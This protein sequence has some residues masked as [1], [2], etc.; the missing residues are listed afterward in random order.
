MSETLIHV[1]IEG[2]PYDVV[3]GSDILPTLGGRIA[4]ICKPKRAFVVTETNVGPLYL[5]QVSSSLEE[6]G[7]AVSTHTYI[8][9]ERSKTI[10]TWARICRAMANAGCDR[11]TV[12]V[13]LGGGVTGDMAGFAAAAFM[14]GI[15]FVQ[16]PTSLLAMVDSSVGGKTGVDIPE[17]KNLVGAFLQPELV[18]ADVNCLA[19]LPSPQLA[20][21]CGE[22]IKH[23]VLADEG[24]LDCLERKPL[25]ASGRTHQEL[26]EIVAAN[27]R[28]K[29]DVVVADE[30]EHGLRQMLNL[31]HTL[32][33]AIE[34]ASD[35]SLGHGS[36][37]AT[38][39]CMVARASASLG[40]C[41]L[42]VADRIERSVAA[43]G[44]P[45]HTDVP[46]GRIL[47][48]AAHD[49]KRHDEGVNLIIPCKIGSCEIRRVNFEELRTVIELG[50]RREIA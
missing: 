39:L 48:L 1:G 2:A 31:G 13:A 50:N 5:E 8:A 34:A 26:V 38:G 46:V 19:T 28:I 7:I 23:A 25:T 3:V 35:Y 10:D 33:H 40:W 9:G 44:L 43:H 17:G 15:R 16:V 24:L 45:T 22:V 11:D 21:A 6:V 20:D 37:V 47:E 41:T 14:R 36:C 29:R 42:D 27:V 18:L 49:K 30:R 32:G 12:V 4:D